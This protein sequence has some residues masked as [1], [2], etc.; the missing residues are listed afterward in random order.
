M[1]LWGFF[2]FMVKPKKIEAEKIISAIYSLKHHATV[3]VLFPRGSLSNDF[4]KNF[5]MQSIKSEL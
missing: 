2:S 5:C 1:I 4:V 3:S